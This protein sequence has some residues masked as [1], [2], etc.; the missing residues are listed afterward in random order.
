MSES[1]ER[2]F[3]L[4]VPGNRSSSTLGTNAGGRND[5]RQANTVREVQNAQGSESVPPREIGEY[6]RNSATPTPEDGDE[7]DE[8]LDSTENQLSGSNGENP[9]IDELDD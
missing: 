4:T 3:A 1:H 5:R 8:Q 7:E 6:Q 2:L 9:E